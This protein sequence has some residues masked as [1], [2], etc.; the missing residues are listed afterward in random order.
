MD[1]VL[2]DRTVVL[3][4]GE[5]RSAAG[6][7]H[8]SDLEAAL[9]A[10]LAAR[11]MQAVSR[12]DLHRDVWGYASGVRSRAVDFTMNRLRRKIEVDPAAP[13]HLL[14]ARNHGYRFVPAH[15]PEPAAAPRSEP[16]PGRADALADLAARL[17]AGARLVTVYGLGGM[18]K[19]YLLRAFATERSAVWVS[20]GRGVNAEEAVR[21][22]LGLPADG[23]LV[24]L[25]R[26]VAASG[27]RV[28]VLDDVGAEHGAV[29]D[30]CATSAVRVVASARLPLG[31]PGEH[32]VALGPLAEDAAVAV[33]TARLTEVRAAPS[34]VEAPA[35]RTLARRLGGWPLALALAASRARVVPLAV[36][37]ERLDP[38]SLKDGAG[39]GL[40]A[41]VGEAL[42]GLEPTLRDALAQAALVPGQLSL[43]AAEA[44]ID[45]PSAVLDVLDGLCLRALLQAEEAE[46]SGR[47]AMPEPVRTA[48][49]ARYAADPRLATWRG[50]RLAWAA[51]HAV[52]V[53][54][55]LAAGRPF[56]VDLDAERAT[57]RAIWDERG[58]PTV[59][60]ARLGAGLVPWLALRASWR[61]LDAFVDAVS[62]DAEVT[63]D[64]R[65]IR[66]VHV[67]R[68]NVLRLVGRYAEALT[69]CDRLLA[70]S[71]SAGLRFVRGATLRRIGR[72][73]EARAD[74]DQAVTLADLVG[75]VISA[76]RAETVAA[77]IADEAGD[78][79][80]AERLARLAVRRFTDAG[81]GLYLAS[82]RVNLAVVLRHAGR[83]EAARHELEAAD[84]GIP[85]SGSVRLRATVLHERAQVELDAGCLDAGEGF[86]LDELATARRFGDR[87]GS[88]WPLSNLGVLAIEQG[89]F[90]LA[91]ERLAEA[92]AV[93]VDVGSRPG[94]MAADANLGI[95][96]LFEG[97]RP[98]AAALL[99]AA[100]ATALEVSQ[101]RHLP[102]LRAFLALAEGA[103][104]PFPTVGSAQDLRLL[105]RLRGQ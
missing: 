93:H 30:A 82:A 7:E 62:A 33:L 29:V 34:L 66:T 69:A 77:L 47:L 67:E 87:A 52:A 16:P 78:A 31:L 35:V 22:A 64:P 100:L 98:R 68:A 96:A 11:P 4:A 97:D 18:G 63:G 20:V 42:D 88:A 51:D 5:V 83:F 73:P 45:V 44:V 24:A 99:E 12:E 38:L 90:G 3:P 56:T 72:V 49:R 79:A 25:A 21:S 60:G 65:L 17:D 48:V 41:I 13:K 37:A 59:D 27:A 10:Y 61:G 53:A 40:D 84:A 71:D 74:L 1:V 43:D 95:L 102:T 6:V 91:A 9:F 39:K 103:E 70:E 89:R 86:A 2:S 92:R 105:A 28:L 54:A 32:T 36:L 15:V 19:T 85:A 50:R 55:K 46:G 58:A 94:V 75:D 101:P 26:S 57:V 8:L 104:V 76:G 81:A 23:G 14:T 80:S